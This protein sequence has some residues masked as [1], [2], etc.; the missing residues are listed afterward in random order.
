MQW[1]GGTEH[2]EAWHCACLLALQR[3]TFGVNRVCVAKSKS[4]FIAFV[5]FPKRLLKLENL[6]NRLST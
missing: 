5:F 3:G 4:G 6:R 1:S 2:A